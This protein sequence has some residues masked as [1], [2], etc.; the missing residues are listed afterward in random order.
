MC[1]N[2]IGLC[3]HKIHGPFEV[4]LLA[5]LGPGAY[6]IVIGKRILVLIS[7]R[8]CISILDLRTW[9]LQSTNYKYFGIGIKSFYNR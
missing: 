8:F 6:E 2:E 7:D 1:D 4:Q 3:A 5:Q 9:N